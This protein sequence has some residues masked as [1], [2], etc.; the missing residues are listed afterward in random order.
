[1]FAE[2]CRYKPMLNVVQSGWQIKFIGVASFTQV[3]HVRNKNSKIQGRSLNVI[4][5]IFHT[6]RKCSVIKERI[7]SL[8]EQILS[9][10][11]SSHFEEGRN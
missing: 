9:F 10:K 11:R 3:T 5:V 6:I 2:V 4:K 7:R 1:M 8:W